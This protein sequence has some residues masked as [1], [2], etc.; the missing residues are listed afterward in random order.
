MIF[1]SPQDFLNTK[2]PIKRLMAI[3]WGSRKIG[4]AMND[5]KNIISY[6]LMIIQNDKNAIKFIED[7][8]RKNGISQMV[9][10]FPVDELGLETKNCKIIIEFAEKISKFVDVVLFDE[11][12]TTRA[13]A[14]SFLELG[15]LGKQSLIASKNKTG[16]RVSRYKKDFSAKKEKY[17]K[18]DQDWQKKSINNLDKKIKVGLNILDYQSDDAGTACKILSDATSIMILK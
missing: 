17:E 12:M 15:S 2:I 14:S 6:P 16:M 11:R 7:E 9:I 5:V 10:G 8:V 1:R 3:D 18:F 4:L 13:F